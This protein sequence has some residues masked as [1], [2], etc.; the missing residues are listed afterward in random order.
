MGGRLRRR[1]E[2]APTYQAVTN[3]ARKVI[4]I[5]TK[6]ADYRRPMSR[7]N[8]LDTKATPT[9]PFCHLRPDREPLTSR[10]FNSDSPQPPIALQDP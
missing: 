8:L 9:N 6:N 1:M 7:M 4:D 5:V 2:R 10:P 3:A